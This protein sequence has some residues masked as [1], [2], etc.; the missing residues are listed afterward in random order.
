MT[1]SFDL[2]AIHTDLEGLDEVGRIAFGTFLLERALPNFF[3]FQLDTGSAGGA[4]L[5]AVSAQCWAA[6]EAST[7]D[8]TKYTSVE[9]CE[10]TLPDSEDHASRYTSAAIDAAN[11]AC[12]LLEYLEGGKVTSLMEAVQARWDT[13][14]VFILNATDIG[15][16]EVLHHPLMQE[17]LRCMHDDI[18]FLRSM[19]GSTQLLH[20]AVFERVR[21]LGYQALR[22]KLESV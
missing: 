8:A 4:V 14:Y 21:R 10:T 2:P 19:S 17:E 22:M 9:A 7:R 5:R 20:T 15:D 6:L 3:Q 13:L 12:C 16:E 18:A 11:I 1:Y